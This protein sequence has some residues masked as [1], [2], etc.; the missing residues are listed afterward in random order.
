M[1][2]AEAADAASWEVFEGH[3]EG[4]PIFAR[5]NTSFRDVADRSRYGIQIGVA[6]PLTEPDQHGLPRQEEVKA[7]DAIEDAVLAASAGNGTLV[8]VITTR[9][10]REFVLYTG[11]SDWIEP[12]HHSLQ[13]RVTTHEVQVMAQRDP[14]WNVYRQ[15]VA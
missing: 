5:F 13:E 7:L 14:E 3:R 1:T 15:F 11:E 4:G 8:G 6:I 12:F 10:M 2:F 9:S